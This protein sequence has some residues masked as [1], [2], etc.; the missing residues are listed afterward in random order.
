MPLARR[1]RGSVTRR[2]L[3]VAALLL[4]VGVLASLSL[5]HCP[6]GV[7]ALT[8]TMASSGSLVPSSPL[9]EQPGGACTSPEVVIAQDT[10]HV[11]R[12]PSVLLESITALWDLPTHD[13]MCGARWQQGNMNPCAA[14]NGRSLLYR[15][16]VIR[17]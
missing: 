3:L 10:A 2:G 12:P 1:D 5:V 13:S 15:I 11:I 8:H 17:R 7:V 4:L 6:K 16:S 9:A 14:Q